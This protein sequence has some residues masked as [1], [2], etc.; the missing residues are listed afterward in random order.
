MIF[1][2]LVFARQ[3][4]ARTL[5][6]GLLG[7]RLLLDREGDESLPLAVVMTTLCSCVASVYGGAMSVVTVPTCGRDTDARR[8]CRP[9]CR[10]RVA[11]R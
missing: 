4:R 5:G 8:R 7:E 6:D 2:R 10:G 3:G 9:C 11:I 1:G